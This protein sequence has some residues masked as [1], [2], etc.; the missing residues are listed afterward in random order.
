MIRRSIAQASDLKPGAL[1]WI[2][3]Y[4][5]KADSRYVPMQVCITKV[6]PSAVLGYIR[7]HYAII[8]PDKY[9]AWNPNNF[10]LGDKGVSPHNYDERCPQVFMTKKVCAHHIA[11]WGD[12]NPNFISYPD[13]KDMEKVSSW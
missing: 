3:G 9:A 12:R 8:N 1:V 10:F 5:G 13:F 6:G 7:A 4:S 11:L 2:A